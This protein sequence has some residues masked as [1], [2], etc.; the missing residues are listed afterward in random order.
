MDFHVAV[1]WMQTFLRQSTVYQELCKLWSV[2]L[3]AN[4]FIQYTCHI[5]GLAPEEK[6]NYLFS[7]PNID[8]CGHQL[9]ELIAL[10]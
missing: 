4:R 3:T 5:Q 10:Q 8:A 1:Y 6:I 2:L 7:H 9:W